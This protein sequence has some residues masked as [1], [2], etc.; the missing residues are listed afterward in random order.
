MHFLHSIERRIEHQDKGYIIIVGTA[1]LDQIAQG[2]KTSMDHIFLAGKEVRFRES[3][4]GTPS[5]IAALSEITL[6]KLEIFR[7]YAIKELVVIVMHKN[8]PQNLDVVFTMLDE[9]NKHMEEVQK[10]ADEIL[11]SAMDVYKCC[12]LLF[13]SLKGLPPNANVFDK[14]LI[15]EIALLGSAITS[16]QKIVRHAISDL[17]NG[18]GRILGTLLN[19]VDA[20]PPSDEDAR[21]ALRSLLD[22]AS[23]SFWF[24]KIVEKSALEE[25]YPNF[26][27]LSLEEMEAVAIAGLLKKSGSWGSQGNEGCEIRNLTVVKLLREQGCQLPTGLEEL[28]LYHNRSDWHRRFIYRVKQIIGEKLEE[29]DK[30]KEIG[31]EVFFGRDYALA[32]EEIK[33]EQNPFSD[34]SGGVPVLLG[35]KPVQSKL[36]IEMLDPKFVAQILI[37]ALSEEFRKAGNLENLS[38]KIVESTEYDPRI[39]KYKH[40]SMYAYVLAAICNAFRLLPL[41]A[42][43]I[44]VDSKIQSRE[45]QEYLSDVLAVVIKTL[46]E[47]DHHS[48]CLIKLSGRNGD[49]YIRLGHAHNDHRVY[50]DRALVIS[51]LSQRT[52]GRFFDRALGEMPKIV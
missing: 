31:T 7:R 1:R 26:E 40:S 13:T 34:L 4:K 10:R 47:K 39:H 38:G 42:M 36:E 45:L 19:M 16:L 27:P 32:E 30:E 23:V 14:G 6:E 2:I 35:Q 8:C 25:I 24:N 50:R 12:C 33:T 51:V 41:G 44:F 3:P 52:F 21:A 49:K 20:L 9:V 11:K 29:G 5:Q 22:A 17:I 15:R 18:T 48:P 37:L 28:V 43:V 46:D